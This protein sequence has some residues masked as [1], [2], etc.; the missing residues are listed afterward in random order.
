MASL[1]ARADRDT[2]ALARATLAKALQKCRSEVTVSRTGYVSSIEDNLLPGVERRQFENDLASG[3]GNELAGKFKAAH[4]SSALVVNSF[5]RFKDN[6]SDL[7]LGGVRKFE[8]LNFE[9][10][11]PVGIRGG[12]PPNLDLVASGGVNVVAV[13]SKCL[14]YLNDRSTPR[15]MADF[16]PAYFEQI[17]DERKTGP[18]FRAMKK[19]SDS[20]P[21][22]RLDAAQLIKHAF[23]LARCFKGLSVTLAYVFWEPTDAANFP[24]FSAHRGEIARFSEIVEG[25]FPRFDP[26]SYPE[27]WS[28]WSQKTC[29]AWLVAHAGNLRARYLVSLTEVELKH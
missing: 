12:T 9:R 1:A 27:L 23:G 19:L 13:E 8:H 18:W 16:Q 22:L 25:G 17:T 29:P 14:E 20:D 5:A 2:A 15:K 3:D 24:V 11:C 10:K 21:F 7:V 4:S 26:I 28:L 6:L